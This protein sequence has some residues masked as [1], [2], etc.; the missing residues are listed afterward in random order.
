MGSGNLVQGNI[1]NV[2]W[3]D[4]WVKTEIEIY[5]NQKLFHNGY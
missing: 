2:N 3:A 1:R 5:G 4:S